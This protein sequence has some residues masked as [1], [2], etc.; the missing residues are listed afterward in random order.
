MLLVFLIFSCN[1]KRTPSDSTDTLGADIKQGNFGVS[2]VL[3]TISLDTMSVDA[4]Y[5]VSNPNKNFV[6]IHYFGDSTVSLRG[7]LMKN[8]NPRST[9]FDSIP[10]VVFEAK[11][12]SNVAI[13]PGTYVGNQVLL[14]KVEKDIVKA[15]NGRGAN[16]L[17][18]PKKGSAGK[19][20]YQILILFKQQE[21]NIP[22][23][24]DYQTNPSPPH[25][26]F[27]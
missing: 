10:D 17:F 18:V 12:K 20:Y 21:F 5:F 6:F 1:S 11:G 25:Q 22:P 23:Q 13:G 8:T 24:D 14:G 3:P 9:Q 27:D 16:L 2:G 4:A 19:I 7:W 26:S 15:I